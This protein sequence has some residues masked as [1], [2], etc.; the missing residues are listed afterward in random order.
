[1]NKLRRLV[2]GI[3]GVAALAIVVPALGLAGPPAV[4][5]HGSFTDGPYDADFCGVPGTQIDTGVFHFLL[6]SSGDAFVG[7]EIF[8]SVFT[9]TATGKSLEVSAAS[10]GKGALTDNG[11]GTATFSEQDAGLVL[12]FKIPNGP[13]L[14]DADG[15]PIL[16]AGVLDLAVTFDLASGDVIS[17]EESWHGPHPLR[18][19]V[20]ICGPAIDYLTS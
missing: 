9:A 2:V 8:D 6:N 1:M 13:V 4:N 17:V 19:G 12:Q 18:D 7:T 15:K 5:E 20:D 3:V 16:G 11:D 10:T 14:K